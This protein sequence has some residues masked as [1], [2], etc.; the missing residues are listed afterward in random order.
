V[1][2]DDVRRA[3]PAF[4]IVGGVAF[5][6]SSVRDDVTLAAQLFGVGAG[7]V[8]VVYGVFRLRVERRRPPSGPPDGDGTPP[9]A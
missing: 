5:A 8:A 7:L 4:F 6:L 1:K 9:P 2:P 3:F